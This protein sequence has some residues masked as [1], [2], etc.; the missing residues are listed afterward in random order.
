MHRADGPFRFALAAGRQRRHAAR[1]GNG[2]ARA[3]LAGPGNR[4]TVFLP[5][6]KRINS[7]ERTRALPIKQTPAHPAEDLHLERLHLR[8][9]QAGAAAVL[10]GG[11]GEVR[12]TTRVTRSVSA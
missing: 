9:V 10:A 2:A 12:R 7:I 8:T 11:V 1:R 3:D 5:G 6:Q 4:L